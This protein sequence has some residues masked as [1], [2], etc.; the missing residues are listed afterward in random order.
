MAQDGE[1]RSQGRVSNGTVKRRNSQKKTSAHV[2][3]KKPIVQ[4]R[5]LTSRIRQVSRTRRMNFAATLGLCVLVAAMM[6]IL[7][8]YIGLQSA[9]TQ[10]NQKITELESEIA[11]KKAANDEMINEINESID[12]DKIREYAMKELGMRYATESQIVYYNGTEE[13]SVHQIGEIR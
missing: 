6:V 9:V 8:L 5:D 3:T 4:Q 1:K 13:D 12:L 2:A 10:T 11:D 7:F